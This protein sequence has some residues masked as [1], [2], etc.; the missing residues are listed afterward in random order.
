MQNLLRELDC[1]AVLIADTD[2]SDHSRLPFPNWKQAIFCICFLSEHFQTQGLKLAKNIKSF[3]W[4][5]KIYLG[6]KMVILKCPPI[7][8]FRNPRH[9]TA[10]F[11]LRTSNK[12]L[13]SWNVSKH[14]FK[15]YKNLRVDSTLFFISSNNNF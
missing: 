6:I 9:P 2:K 12:R 1:L 4:L 13:C 8:H 11:R 15:L 14:V 3:E 5:A 10:D 7:E